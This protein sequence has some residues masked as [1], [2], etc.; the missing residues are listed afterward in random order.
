VPGTNRRPKERKRVIFFKER[1]LGKKIKKSA[2]LGEQG[3]RSRKKKRE[4]R[5]LRMRGGTRGGNSLMVRMM[6][7]EAR[8]KEGKKAT[9]R[10]HGYPSLN[11]RMNRAGW[12]SLWGRKFRRDKKTV[13]GVLGEPRN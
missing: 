2:F 3:L 9:S 1:Y 8:A 5:K 11:G 7:K 10:T 12:A 6:D 13:F 4:G